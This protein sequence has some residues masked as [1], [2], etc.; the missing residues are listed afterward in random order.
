[1]L[2]V[3]ILFDLPVSYAHNQV[4]KEHVIK[5]S[6]EKKGTNEENII[7]EIEGIMLKRSEKW[8][9]VRNKAILKPNHGL[10]RG[11]ML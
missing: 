5:C 6:R 9:K 3:I 2:I 10:W 4:K 7:K 11:N 8:S 1:M